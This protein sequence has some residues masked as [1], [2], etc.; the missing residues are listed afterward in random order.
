MNE[1]NCT[2][3][4]RCNRCNVLRLSH[5][6]ILLVST[7]ETSNPSLAINLAVF[8]TRL[9]LAQ[10]VKQESESQI[11]FERVCLMNNSAAVY[12]FFK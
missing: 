12:G 5:P 6:T 9:P 3:N 8:A 11:G 7:V 2:D 4:L 10:D 1:V